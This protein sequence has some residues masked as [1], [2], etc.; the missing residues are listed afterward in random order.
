[1]DS[2][3]VMVAG[4][5][6]AYQAS[7]RLK[8]ESS[9]PYM[10]MWSRIFAFVELLYYSGYICQDCYLIFREITGTP[11]SSPPIN[12]ILFLLEESYR[13]RFSGGNFYRDYF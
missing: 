8:R 11:K 2:F 6:Q 1:M 13:E 4:F 9:Y 5:C 3:K 12:F 10:R 7:F